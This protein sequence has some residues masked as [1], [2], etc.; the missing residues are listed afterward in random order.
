M[1]N[2]SERVQIMEYIFCVI[3]ILTAIIWTIFNLIIFGMTLCCKCGDRKRKKF[4]EYCYCS[5][6][7]AM[8]IGVGI[9]VAFMCFSVIL[10]N[11]S[12]TSCSDLDQETK[13]FIILVLFVSMGVCGFPLSMRSVRR[14]KKQVNAIKNGEGSEMMH[15]SDQ[16]NSDSRLTISEANYIIVIMIANTAFAS[17]C[18]VLTICTII[19]CSIN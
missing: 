2:Q 17:V 5:W 11:F 13:N 3:L 14:M 16:M 4:V 6:N 7:S 8:C 15:V 1:G 9:I 12:A 18:I 19:D 10:T